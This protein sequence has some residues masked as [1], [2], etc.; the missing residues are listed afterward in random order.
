[1]NFLTEEEGA[2]RIEA[3]YR[4]TNYRRLVA[5]KNK[6]DPTN[7]FRTNKN[8]VPDRLGAAARERRQG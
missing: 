4:G 6:Y 1:M 5:L 7:L 3:A 8:I 2:E